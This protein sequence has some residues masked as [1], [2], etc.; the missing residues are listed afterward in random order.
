[1]PPIDATRPRAITDLQFREADTI[2]SPKVT[3]LVVRAQAGD[4][5]AFD[6]LMVL[7][8][9]RVIS[10][11]MQMG[12][13]NADAQDACQ[14]AFIKVFRY[15]RC[16]RSGG[17]FFKWL[18]RIAI[19]A[20]YDHLRRNRTCGTISIEDLSPSQIGRIRE[21]GPSLAGR[22]EAAELASKLLA[23]LDRLSRRERVVF[24]L[25]DL[26]GIGTGEIGS[27]LCLSQV[28]VRRHCMTARQKLRERL[29]GPRD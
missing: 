21:T 5:A 15:I 3:G 1:M 22:V 18:Y 23:G 28:T 9:R 7:Y 12:L 13:S 11:G 24:V 26:Q 10:L 27:I 8:E 2:E 20:I 17:S 6:D 4:T 25:R 14:D 29:F 19:H 16:F